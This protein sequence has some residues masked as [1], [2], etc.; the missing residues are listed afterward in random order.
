M[1]TPPNNSHVMGNVPK[2]SLGIAGGILNMSRTFGMSLGITLGGLSYQF[3]LKLYGD[4]HLDHLVITFRSAYFIIAVFSFLSLIITSRN[5]K[6][7]FKNMGGYHSNEV[8][9]NR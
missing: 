5:Y 7:E 2:N 8:G 4:N 6:N 3:F 1:F 9:I